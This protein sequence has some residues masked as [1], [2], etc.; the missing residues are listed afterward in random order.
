MNNQSLKNILIVSV[1]LFGI[2]I[3]STAIVIA[4]NR[5]FEFSTDLTN[6]DVLTAISFVA[7]CIAVIW[8]FIFDKTNKD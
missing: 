8:K 6:E 4:F 3:V 5:I 1:A 7:F 2:M